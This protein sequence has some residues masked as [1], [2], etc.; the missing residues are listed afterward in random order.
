VSHHDRYQGVDS[1]SGNDK[2][3]LVI[4]MVSKS[5]DDEMQASRASYLKVYCRVQSA[6]LVGTSNSNNSNALSFNER[7]DAMCEVMKCDEVSSSFHTY[8]F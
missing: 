2:Q 3:L 1:I 7:F 5:I 6:E 8:D 4:A